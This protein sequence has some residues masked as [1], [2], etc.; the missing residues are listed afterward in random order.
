MRV[1]ILRIED[2]PNWEAAGTRVQAALTALGIVASI[3]YRQLQTPEDAAAVPFAG[4]PTILV[5]GSDLFPANGTIT[6]LACRVY[7]T[8]TGLA[9]L[10]TEDQITAAL[11][12]ALRLR[13]D[14]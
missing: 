3:K 6:E 1:E 7:P 14:R 11:Q 13:D 8:P 12:V 2:C 5:N 10:P 4:S 9:G